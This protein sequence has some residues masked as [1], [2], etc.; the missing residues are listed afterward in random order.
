[1]LSSPQG[2]ILEN[3]LFSNI[4]RASLHIYADEITLGYSRKKI[5][6]WGVED[7]LF[8]KP[9]WNFSFFTLPLEIADKTKLN[10]WIFHKIVLD[11][12][13]IPRPKAKTPSTLFLLVHPRKSHFVFNW[14]RKLHMLF[15]MIPLE[16]PYP[17]PNPSLPLPP[18]RIF[19]GIAHSTFSQL[20]C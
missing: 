5:Q 13:E 10:L 11:P 17:Q 15:L 20:N 14:P 6:T 18:V 4:M 3:L 12:L 8:W 7:I 16:I 19:S 1:M 2:F 9:P